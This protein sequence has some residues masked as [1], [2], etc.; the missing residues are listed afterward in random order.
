ML[1]ALALVALS[2]CASKPRSPE[3]EIADWLQANQRQI[4]VNVVAQAEP[5]V[6]R[7]RLETSQTGKE[8]AK[9]AAMGAVV[10]A[11]AVVGTLIYGG[12]VGW[13]LL[14]FPPTWLVVGGVGAAGAVVG[15]TAG[16]VTAEPI[17]E[18]RA[19]EAA[20]ALETFFADYPSATRLTLQLGDALAA[21]G[22]A[23]L[24][25]DLRRLP[26]IE[27]EATD[28]AAGNLLAE[29]DAL[30]G[31]ID[32][33]PLVVDLMLSAGDETEADPK[34]ALHFLAQTN[35][36][37]RVGSRTL[38]LP[39]GSWTHRSGRHRLSEWRAEPGDLMT[40]ET[41]EALAAL[42]DQIIAD[43]APPSE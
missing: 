30:D 41:R 8:A 31:V 15:G 26:L 14:A 7:L 1:L 12:P 33:R 17:V 25:H 18:T 23:R 39:P 38:G 3:E 36:W 4:G 6:H 21:Q 2:A 11:G 29:R 22:S 28:D 19:L 34:A 13:L 27:D 42:A 24:P 16:A 20:P 9:G 5:D 10:G 37:F 40:E 35:S 43:F 32:L